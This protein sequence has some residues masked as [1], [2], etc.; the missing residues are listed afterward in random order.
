MQIYKILIK[1]KKQLIYFFNNNTYNRKNP[2]K[3]RNETP[4]SQTRDWIKKRENPAWISSMVGHRIEISN[5]FIE[6]Y[7]PVIQCV[8]YIRLR[9]N[10][11]QSLATS[12]PYQREVWR[13]YIY[14]WGHK[15]SPATKKRETEV[16]PFK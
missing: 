2:K 3:V 5:L 14:S 11:R 4:I 1:N 9:S 15:S 12:L 10:A 8:E 16:S 6:D 7:E 13:D